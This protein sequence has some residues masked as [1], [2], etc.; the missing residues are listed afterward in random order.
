MFLLLFIPVMLSSRSV[1]SDVLKESLPTFHLS[2]ND[3]IQ[4]S[5]AHFLPVKTMQFNT[6][7]YIDKGENILRVPNITLIDDREKRKTLKKA[8]KRTIQKIIRKHRS[9]K[10][11]S[12]AVTQPSPTKEQF[13]TYD[14]YAK[15]EML[16]KIN[17][18]N[19]T[20]TQTN[21][22]KQ[23]KWNKLTRYPMP[24]QKMNFNREVSKNMNVFRRNKRSDDKPDVMIL[25]DLDEIQFLNKDKDYNVV[26]AHLQ[27][28]W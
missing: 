23:K 5:L 18:T 19:R 2:Q 14:I 10:K 28:H 7:A 17:L 9:K 24:F 26:T 4:S 15:E 11:N 6:T 3:L 25:K 21:Q 16:Q 8:P 12:P 22:K 13:D 27:K 1:R 20:T